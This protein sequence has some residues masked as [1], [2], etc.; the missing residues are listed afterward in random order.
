MNA[1]YANYIYIAF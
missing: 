1:Y